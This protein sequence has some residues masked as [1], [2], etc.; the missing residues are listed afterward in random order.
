MG[1]SAPV[2]SSQTERLKWEL[3]TDQD[4]RAQLG[5]VLVQLTETQKDLSHHM[6]KIRT[7]GELLKTLGMYLKEN[8][9]L[10][11]Q[12]EPEER[13]K[14]LSAINRQE[15]EDS[16]KSIDH[17]LAKREELENLKNSLS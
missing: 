12:W 9:N 7:M 6:H 4:K 8:G 17:L 5:E 1:A 2:S 10:P 13:E 3:M 11:N 14:H 16:L 15:I